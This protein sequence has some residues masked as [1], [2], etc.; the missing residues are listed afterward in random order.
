MPPSPLPLTAA[1]TV[2][3]LRERIADWRRAGH[4]VGFVP[5]MGALHEGH[6]ALVRQALGAADRV[7]VSIF[8][9]P[10]QFAEG[11]D[12]DSYPRTLDEDAAKLA[13]TGAQLIYAPSARQMYPEGFA[14][15]VRMG[16][17]AEGLES[18]ARPHFFHGVALVVAKLLNQVRP[19]IAVFGEKDYQQLLVIRR[20][21]LDLDLNVEILAGETVREADGLALSSRN[22]YLNADER[23]RAGQLNVILAEFAQALS[24]GAAAAAAEAEAL[25]KAE[26]AFDAVDYVTARDAE[27][28]AALGPGPVEA[29]ARVLAAV[30]VGSTRL[31]DNMAVTPR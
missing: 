22:A 20:L 15:Q 10:A 7:V 1:L 26:A 19:D 6:L 25:G 13:R 11:E 9:N 14:T 16:G 28:L 21:A 2:A 24:Q 8:V 18:A 31:I 27:T 5:T 29:P 12:F 23:R 3:D 4:R 17:P 30:K